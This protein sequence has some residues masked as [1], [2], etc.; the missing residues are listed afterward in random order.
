MTIDLSI[1]LGTSRSGFDTNGATLSRV[2]GRAGLAFLSMRMR[3][4]ADFVEPAV[5]G[6]EEWENVVVMTGGVFE[7]KGLSDRR[8]GEVG[9]GREGGQ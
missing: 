5:D 6:R 9:R 7:D 4:G 2:S 1:G 8:R 3:G